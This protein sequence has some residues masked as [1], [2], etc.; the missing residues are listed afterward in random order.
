MW[1]IKNKDRHPKIADRASYLASKMQ[2]VAQNYRIQGLAAEMSKLACIYM[3]EWSNICQLALMVHDELIVICREEHK[4][5]V[6]T[7]LKECMERAFYHYCKKVK[8]NVDVTVT[9]VWK[10]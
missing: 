7:A 6:S 1:A 9:R 5:L 2:R 3:R 10:K 8:I 4:D